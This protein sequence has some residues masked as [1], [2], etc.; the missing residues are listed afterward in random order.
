MTAL[1]V[2]EASSQSLPAES[3]KFHLGAEMWPGGQGQTLQTLAKVQWKLLLL[4][5]GPGV[6]KYPLCLRTEYVLCVIQSLE[7]VHT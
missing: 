4:T 1:G 5:S 6:E 3:G 2:G 7:G